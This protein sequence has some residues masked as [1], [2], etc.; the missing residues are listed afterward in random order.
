MAGGDWRDFRVLIVGC[1]SIGRRHARVLSSLG[2]RRLALCDPS[3]A[4]RESLKAELGGVETY[5]DYQAALATRPEAVFICT[6]TSLHVP[7]AVAALEAGAHV[8]MEKPLSNTLEGTERLRAV[9]RDSGKTFMVAFCFRFHEGLTR[10]KAYVE[11]GRIGRLLAARF[12]MSENLAEVRPDYRE[13]FT[14][15]EGGVYDLTHE[16]D[17]ACWFFAEAPGR[18]RAMHGTVSELGFSAPDIALVDVEFPGGG[19]AQVYLDFFSIP[20]TRVTELMGTEGTIR[21][22]FAAWEHCSVAV[23]SRS[24]PAW[25][26]EHLSTERDAMFRAEDRE[27]L[28]A[29]AGG[30]ALSVPLEEGLKSLFILA[31][32]QKRGTL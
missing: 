27:F 16:L 8:M 19:M 12:R 11:E 20:R 15:R 18:V 13:L 29:A 2:V 23:Y 9:I 24:E 14:L 21:V 31:E 32:A 10:A 4:G 7:M 17:L 28:R 22:E 1:G 26:Q 30:G 5:S 25:R 6:P 3:E